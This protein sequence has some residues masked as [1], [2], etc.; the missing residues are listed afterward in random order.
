MKKKASIAIGVIAGLLAIWI[1]IQQ[2][3][4]SAVLSSFR[5]F[6]I[7]GLL[8]Y[9]G[10]SLMVMIIFALRWQ[11]IIRQQGYGRVPF[12]DVFTFRMV[13]Y[14]VSFLTPFAKVGGEPVRAALLQ[15]HNMT[16]KQG[17]S[18]V[19]IDK[20]LELFFN[21]AFFM[22]GGCYLLIKAVNN[23]LILT[24]SV[25][26]ILF[27]AVMAFIMIQLFQGKKIIHKL[28][29]AT[30]LYRIKRLRKHELRLLE[31]DDM[32]GSFYKKKPGSVLVISVFS[33]VAWIFTFL[34]F[35][36]ALAF[37]GITHPTFLNIFLVLSFVGIGYLFPIPM[38]LGS[39]E[40]SQ[41]SVFSFIKAPASSG[42]ALAAVVRTRDLL[43]SLIGMA[44]LTY[45]GLNVRKVLGREGIKDDEHYP[46]RRHKKRI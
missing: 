41:V 30:G 5:N 3:S 32:I 6:T 45:Y 25:V 31:I 4:L 28:F 10:A 8:L 27:F 37:V 46:V 14:G 42:V 43:W 21:G 1:I 20:T 7:K 26:A 15:R 36:Y 24:L 2:I 13:G 39:L 38:A 34:E 11:Y 44:A 40:A 19:I 17:L 12:K 18:T 16:F 9:L 22:I 23:P 29:R 35:K 33:L